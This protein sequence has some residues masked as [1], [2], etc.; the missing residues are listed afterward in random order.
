LDLR[1][2]EHSDHEITVQNVSSEAY[3]VIVVAECEGGLIEYPGGVPWTPDKQEC[4]PRQT[5]SLYREKITLP[6]GTDEAALPAYGH[7][8]VTVDAQFAVPNAA[9]QPQETKVHTL[10]LSV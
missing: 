3:A 6:A 4:N 1:R 10:S 5:T 7:V 2:G 9:R 8:R